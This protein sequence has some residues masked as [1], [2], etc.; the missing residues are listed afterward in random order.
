M[1]KAT[2]T[3]KTWQIDIEE[4]ESV[5]VYLNGEKCKNSK[6]ALRNISKEICFKYDDNWNTQFFGKKLVEKLNQIPKSSTNLGLSKS[7]IAYLKSLQKDTKEALEEYAKMESYAIQEKLLQ[8]LVKEYPNHANINA[9][10]AKVKLLN[11]FYSTGIKATN[12]MT[13]NILSIKDI[14]NRLAEGDK[15]LV[16]EIAKLQLDKKSRYN[17]SF[18]TKYCAYHQPDKFPIYD[19]IV[20]MTFVSLFMKGLLP[21]Y[22][23]SNKKIKGY[24]HRLNAFTKTGFTEK[25]KDYNFFVEVYDYFMESYDLKNKFSYREVD[26]YI[27]GAFKVTKEF[28]IERMANLDKSKIVEYKIECHTFIS[29]NN[30]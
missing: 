9:V 17:Y 28:E 24:N 12:K 16:S 25:L 2:A 10:E 5:T 26:S 15:S 22:I 11:L 4:N 8:M 7:N 19:S 21:K 18:A 1:L 30:N 3:Y 6:E 23:Y 14:D 13:E 27:W 20:A 29:K